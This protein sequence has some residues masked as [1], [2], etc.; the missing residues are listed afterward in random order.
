MDTEKPEPPY[1]NEHYSCAE[2]GHIFGK[3]YPASKTE[4]SRTCVIPGCKE[5]QRKKVL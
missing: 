1:R 4:V 3:F 2:S 5:T